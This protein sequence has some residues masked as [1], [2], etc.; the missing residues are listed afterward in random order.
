MPRDLAP[1]TGLLAKE[2]MIA[3]GQKA[4]ELTAQG[5]DV[6]LLS[7]GDPMFESPAQAIEAAV[8]GL[9]TNKTHYCDSH[10]TLELRKAGAAYLSEVRP[11]LSADPSSI[12]AGPGA[13]PLIFT[14]MMA[15][16][17]EGDEAIY[18]NPG[19]PSF[20]Q[21]IRYAGATPVAC[22][23][24]EERQFRMD[25]EDVRSRITSRTKL[26]VLNSPH[27]PTGAVLTRE[28]VEMMASLCREHDL[29]VLSDEIYSRNVYPGATFYSIVSEPGMLERT[30]VLDGPIKSLAMTGWRVGLAL[31]PP[32]LTD[33]LYT[34]HMN[35]WSCLPEFTQAGAA[36]ALL[37][38]EENT[39]KMNAEYLWR[40]DMIVDEVSKMR[41]VRK[42]TKPNGAFYVFF[43]VDVGAIPGQPSVAGA[44]RR[45][46]EKILDTQ[47][48]TVA[49]G[50]AFGEGGEGCIRI[51]FC[52]GTRERLAEGLRRLALGL[53]D[54]ALHG[55]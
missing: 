44:T 28:D 20:E 11:G 36:V 22:P 19:F 49:P 33:A 8:N 53:Q 29:Y 48:V 16:L 23:L 3:I 6:V 43:S 15:L 7:V 21:C 27:N 32:H 47:L 38:A 18:P 35:L 5:K 55:L 12:L 2:G 24:R 26:L 31:Y 13:K 17:S 34:L 37:N 30:I 52:S 40:R 54:I 39:A 51:S 45:M 25:P 42:C 50:T 46:C 14:T 1:R 9:Q 4:R 41:L 10:G